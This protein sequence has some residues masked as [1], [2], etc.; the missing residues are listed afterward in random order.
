MLI[1]ILALANSGQP[2]PAPEPSA[3][4]RDTTRTLVAPVGEAL[5]GAWAGEWAEA[6]ARGPIALE[7]AFTAAAARTVFAYFTFIENGVR[8]TVLR[9]GVFGAEGL[10]FPWPGGRRLD[11]RL[12]DSDRLEGAMVKMGDGAAGVPAGSVSLSRRPR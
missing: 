12:T 7:A 4:V 10:R 3:S 6:G 8:R 2:S 1:L 11:L 9:Q 5:T